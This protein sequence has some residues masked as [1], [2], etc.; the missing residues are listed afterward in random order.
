VRGSAHRT[1]VPTLALA[2]RAG[3]WLATG[4]AKKQGAAAVDGTTKYRIGPRA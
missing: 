2:F 3:L 4:Q 1:V